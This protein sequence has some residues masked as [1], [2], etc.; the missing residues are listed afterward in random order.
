M[1]IESMRARRPF[2]IAA[3]TI[4]WFAL[5]QCAHAQAGPPLITNDPGT[6][7][8]GHWEINLAAT[9]SRTTQQRDLAAPDIDI[10]YGWGDD[11]QFSMHVPW[12]HRRAADQAWASAPGPVELAIRW[13]FWD[14]DR[15]PVSLAIQP[16]WV[17]AGLPDAVR[18]EL[19]PNHHEF[20][21]PLQ[22]AKSFGKSILGIEVARHFAAREPD[23]WQSGVFWA[24]T[25]GSGWQCLAEF[26]SIKAER[27]TMESIVNVG[28]R[29][30]LSEH[31]ILMG[32]LGTQVSGGSPRSSF[33]FYLGAQLLH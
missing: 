5:G 3:V 22:A 10:N 21:L 24:R 31:V 14:E 23:A 11:V 16:H 2:V 9:G 18:K 29:R 32:S 26:N 25:C 8:D 30:A 27:A 17:S 33:V 6:P 1:D 13:R 20:V 15:H 19:A 4:G 12:N 7:G 28:A